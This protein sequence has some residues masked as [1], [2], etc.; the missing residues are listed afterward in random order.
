MGDFKVGPGEIRET[1]TGSY[2]IDTR[3]RRGGMLVEFAE[4][5]K[6]QTEHL[7]QEAIKQTVDMDLSKRC[8]NKR[9]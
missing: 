7:F 8:D 6:F 5:H 1:C 2:V 4:R 3:N 9:G